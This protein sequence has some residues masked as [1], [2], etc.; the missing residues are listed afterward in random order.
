LEDLQE[1]SLEVLVHLEDLFQE[2]EVD[3]YRLSEDLFLQE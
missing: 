3:W 1:G 2:K